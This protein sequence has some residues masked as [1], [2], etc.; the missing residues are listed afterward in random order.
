MIKKTKEGLPVV[1]E[2]TR[3]IFWRDFEQRTIEGAKSYQGYVHGL[4]EK[5]AEENLVVMEAWME[6]L[7]SNKLEERNCA[8]LYMAGAMITYEL[9]KRQAQADNLEEMLR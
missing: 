2:K 5:L 3:E 1:S 7:K 4:V 9:L 6:Y 8:Q